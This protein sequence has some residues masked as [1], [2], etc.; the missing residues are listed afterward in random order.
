VFSIGQPFDAQ[1]C[2]LRV[3]CDVCACGLLTVKHTH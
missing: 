1:G 3:L 2:L